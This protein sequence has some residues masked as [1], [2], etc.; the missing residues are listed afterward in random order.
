M[1]GLALLADQT[2]GVENKDWHKKNP[3]PQV[4]V[5]TKPTNKEKGETEERRSGNHDPKHN[6]ERE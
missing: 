4:L 1:A 5:K 3:T 2:L 6:R